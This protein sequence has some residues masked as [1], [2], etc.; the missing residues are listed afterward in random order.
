MAERQITGRHVLIGFVA[1]FAVI[2]GVN[3]VLAYSAVRTFPGLEVRNGYI[4]SQT[5]NERKAA[6]EA[7]GWTLTAEARDGR[8]SLR[9]TGADGQAVRPARVEAT[10]GR[11]TEDHEDISTRLSYTGQGFEA[12]VDLGAGKWILRL[13]AYSADGILFQQRREILTDQ[14]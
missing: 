13:R 1:A 11:A 14:S 3:L 8:L 4:A 5:F 10:I 6:Q 9:F 7:L 2:I 12:P